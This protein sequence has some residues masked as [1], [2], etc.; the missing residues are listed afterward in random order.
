[1]NVS[2]GNVSG[3]N[4]VTVRVGGR[5]PPPVPPPPVLMQSDS[6]K[7]VNDLQT[8]P[9]NGVSSINL[10]NN[11]RAKHPTDFYFNL[12]SFETCMMLSFSASPSVND[13]S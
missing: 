12:E 6:R 4:T 10:G 3:N 5:T 8:V 11:F 9:V 13:I 7:E 2:G 1:M